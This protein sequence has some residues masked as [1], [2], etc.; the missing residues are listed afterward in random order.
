MNTPEQASLHT[1]GRDRADNDGIPIT[2]RLDPGLGPNRAQVMLVMCHFPVE[3]SGEFS[4]AVHGDHFRLLD[5]D[6][7]GAPFDLQMAEDFP[8]HLHH[9]HIQLDPE[10]RTPEGG[11]SP[12]PAGMAFSGQAPICVSLQADF[13]QAHTQIRFC[14]PLR[15]K[16]RID[17]GTIQLQGSFEFHLQDYTGPDMRTKLGTCHIRL[18]ASSQLAFS[19]D[20]KPGHSNL[21]LNFAGQQATA[22]AQG[23]STRW[24]VPCCTSWSRS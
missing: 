17:Q 22:R 2:F 18:N 15:F 20:P 23:R 9:I 13:Y 14:T 5:L 19:F 3:L 1:T 10:G 6:L 24:R 7:Q 12:A 21:R 11:F 16:G 4:L 8:V